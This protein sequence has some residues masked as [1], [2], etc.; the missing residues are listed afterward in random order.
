MNR[1]ARTAI[2]AICTSSFLACSSA[3]TSP[4]AVVDAGADAKIGQ[5]VVPQTDGGTGDGG[6]PCEPHIPSAKL[7][8]ALVSTQG[9][10]RAWT[11]RA[12]S[13]ETF[14]TLSVR[15]GNGASAGPSSGTFGAEQLTPSKAPVTLLLQTEC[16]AHGDH[17]HCGPSFISEQGTWSFTKLDDTKGGTFAVTFS[18]DLVEAKV[19]ASAATPVENGTRLCVRDIALSGS[20]T[21]P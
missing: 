21:E 16:E 20:L 17:Y 8:D 19:T 5:P 18:A 3:S 13:G 14:L 11:I 2:A 15:E 12:R 4:T 1:I 6:S 9:G 10:K 7:E